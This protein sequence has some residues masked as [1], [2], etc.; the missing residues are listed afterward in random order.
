MAHSP[1]Q[2]ARVRKFQH[3]APLD[4]AAEPPIDRYCDLVMTGG[5]TDGVVYPW[6]IVELARRYRFKNIGGTSV[7]AMA[8]ALTAAAEY[9]RRCGSL[10]GFNEVLL[11]LPRKL[12]E[13]IDGKGTTRIFSLFQPTTSTRR[14]FDL[15]VSLFGSGGFSLEEAATC[16]TTQD[17]KAPNRS[18]LRRILARLL[19]IVRHLLVL[20]RLYWREALLGGFLGLVAFLLAVGL[21][22]DALLALPPWDIVIVALILVF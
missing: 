9:G 16:Y 22:L 14:L 13:D 1:D 11:K 19:T 21:G 8:A 7:G 4:E 18:G 6:A 10:F 15:F 5:V 17:G 12:G 20:F 3:P 2:R